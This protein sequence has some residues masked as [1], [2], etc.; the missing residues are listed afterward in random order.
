M[1]DE[2]SKQKYFAKSGEICL[3]AV[4]LVLPIKKKNLPKLK[5]EN[6]TNLF[7]IL[8]GVVGKK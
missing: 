3:F 4:P 5:N 6:Q 8:L 1:H 2:K 7:K